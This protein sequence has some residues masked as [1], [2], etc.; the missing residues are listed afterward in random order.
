MR[1]SIRDAGDVR[2]LCVFRIWALVFMLLDESFYTWPALTST[3]KYQTYILDVL[4]F[5]AK[6]RSCSFQNKDV[7][8]YMCLAKEWM[9]HNGCAHLYLYTSRKF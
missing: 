1:F 5:W 6:Q 9:T 3:L 8:V 4:D 7:Y 2:V